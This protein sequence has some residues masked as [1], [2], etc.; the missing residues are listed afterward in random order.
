MANFKITGIVAASA[1]LLS[2]I[3]GLFSQVTPGALFLRAL[4]SGVLFGLLFTCGS[5]VFRRFLPELFEDLPAEASGD[6][7]EGAEG[8]GGRLNIVL[9]GEGEEASPERERAFDSG[10]RSDEEGAFSGEDR[11][12]G[13]D[14]SGEPELEPADE[15]PEDSGFRPVKLGERLEEEI[16]EAEA[17]DDT[18]EEIPDIGAFENQFQS[19]DSGVDTLDSGKSGGRTIDLLGSEHDPEEAAKAI[20]TILKKEQEG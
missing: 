4:G 2:L 20:Q 19:G 6:A 10:S 17:V 13:D 8:A 15:V 9:D 5:W 18:G 1:A 7:D 12:F 14:D 3:L 11:G 16:E